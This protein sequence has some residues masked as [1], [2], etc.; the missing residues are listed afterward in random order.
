[1]KLE[2]EKLRDVLAEV[3]TK[4]DKPM[5]QFNVDDGDD[6][7]RFYHFDQLIRGGYIR[8]LDA[9]H[10]GG[11]AYIVLDL[12]LPGHELLKKMRSDTVWSRTKGRIAELGG[13]VPIRVLEKLLDSGWDTLIG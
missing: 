11:S 7:A 2:P 1:M 5:A 6:Y 9:S 3:E 13:E 8:A 10:M 4:I 12:T